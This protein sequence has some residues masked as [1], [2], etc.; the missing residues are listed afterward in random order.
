MTTPIFPSVIGHNLL[1][2]GTD[3][4]DGN[5]YP[6]PLLQEYAAAVVGAA[7]VVSTVP[8]D[9][10]IG[11]STTTTGDGISAFTPYEIAAPGTYRKARL[12]WRNI[13]AASDRVLYV[14]A[15]APNA[16]RGLKQS[17][18]AKRRDASIVFGDHLMLISAEPI[19]SLV[20]SSDGSISAN[21]HNLMISWGN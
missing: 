11:P 14:A 18:D 2:G 12:Y 15:N 4:Q 13:S 8:S 5:N 19:T 1:D 9:I 10:L 17:Q 3:A 6:G 16:T 21:T 7:G 20:F